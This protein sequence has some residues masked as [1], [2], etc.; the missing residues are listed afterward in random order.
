M[1]LQSRLFDN[2]QDVLAGGRAFEEIDW[3]AVEE[4]LAVQT[5]YAKDWLAK[6]LAMPAKTNKETE[7]TKRTALRR[8]KFEV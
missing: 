3:A 8:A 1:G 5:A 4:R 6:A 2:P 7:N